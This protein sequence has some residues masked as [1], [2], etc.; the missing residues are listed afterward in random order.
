MARLDTA[1]DARILVLEDGLRRLAEMVGNRKFKF[2][3]E[4]SKLSEILQETGSLIYEVKYSYISSKDVAELPATKK[5]VDGVSQFS[6][7][8][9]HAV[10]ATGFKPTTTKE[11]F[12][13]AEASYVFRIAESFETR[14]K[15]S[16]DDPAYAVDILAVEVSQ[17]QPVPESK[18]L[19]ECRCTDGSRIWRILT[20]ISGVKPKTKLAC[21]V[22]PP[23]EMMGIVSEAMFLGGDPLP[24]D[25]PLGTL[26]DPPPAALSQAR[27]QVLQ[28]IKRMM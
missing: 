14:M 20:N 4:Y 3:V 16:P 11:V 21:A 23:A 18:N 24:D 8:V 1:K 17:A 10:K 12:T 25:T 26:H 15:E 27:A 2:H 22:L 5:I 9:N 7:L 28:V 6:K 13:L 19:T